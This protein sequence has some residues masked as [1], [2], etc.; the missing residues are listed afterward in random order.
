MKKHFNF[1]IK[2][3]VSIFLIVFIFSKV[4]FSDIFKILQ[5]FNL[6]YIL[7]S[8]F[9]VILCYIIN[10]IKWKMLLDY[11]GFR[12]RFFSLFKLNLIAIFY[13]LVLPGG[14]ITGEAVKCFKIIKRNNGN[15]KGRLI[16]T[17]LMDKITGFIG[18]II[19]GLIGI[20]LSDKQVSEYRNILMAFIFFSLVSI[21]F[22]F[23]FNEK[24]S[25]IVKK[26]YLFLFKKESKIKELIERGIDLIFAYK[27]AYDVLL[28]SVVYGI[29]F[30]FFNTLIVY[31]LALSIKVDVSLINLLWI[32]SL[33]NMVLII[34]VTI[35]GIGLREWSLVYFL[36]LINISYG[37]SLSLSMLIFFVL[38]FIGL[39]GGIIELK[40]IL[41]KNE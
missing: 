38:L 6:F 29:L 40:E 36:G 23:L 20:L 21:F 14:Q 7:I 18:F 31:F 16:I 39:L 34:P 17:V 15:G 9:F 26:I 32:V 1:F 8:L 27:N 37:E 35:L 10:S 25:I 3:G 22:L 41:K 12:K 24:I 33:V 11:F 28:L 30:Q 4:S 5:S 2:L 13:G 19:L